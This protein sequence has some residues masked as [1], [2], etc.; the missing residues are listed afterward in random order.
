MDFLQSRPQ[1]N[2]HTGQRQANDKPGSASSDGLDDTAE[3]EVPDDIWRQL[4]E[5][6]RSSVEGQAMAT[7]FVWSVLGGQWTA[8][9]K[10]VVYDAF[11]GRST[12]ALS[13]QWA[14]SHS[15]LASASFSV[16]LYGDEGAQ[17]LVE[18]WVHR[19]NSFYTISRGSLCEQFRFSQE[20]LASVRNSD[21]FEHARNAS[22]GAV[23]SRFEAV[24]TL[25]PH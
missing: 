21:A 22:V 25:A 10:G 7:P 19:M 5:R 15:L 14:A 9:H 3:F 11:K 24:A 17:L 2:D 13:K 1:T 6:R 8:A 18:T 23:R 12:S 20:Q 16:K 4:E